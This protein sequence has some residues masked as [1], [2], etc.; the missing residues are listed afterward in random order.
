[1]TGA[2]VAVFL[3]KRRVNSLLDELLDKLGD[4]YN[5]EYV[6]TCQPWIREVPFAE[7]FEKVTSA[8]IS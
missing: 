2:V 5:S 8:W 6:E 4:Y 3:K 7:W 1:M